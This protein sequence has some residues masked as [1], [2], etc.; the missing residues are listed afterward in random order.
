MVV[1]R[2][3]HAIGMMGVDGFVG[4]VGLQHFDVGDTVALGVEGEA[5]SGHLWEVAVEHGSHRRTAR[6]HGLYLLTTDGNASQGVVVGQHADDVAIGDVASADVVTDAT[7]VLHTDVSLHGMAV[8]IGHDVAGIGLHATNLHL[9][10]LVGHLEGIVAMSYLLRRDGFHQLADAVGDGAD[11]GVFVGDFLGF[12]KVCRHTTVRS[13]EQFTDVGKL[14]TGLCDN[15]VATVEILDGHTLEN[16]VGMAI[17]HDIDAT[18]IV[19]EQVGIEAQR[20]GGLTDVGEQYHVVGTLAT[21][22]IDGLLDE[23]VEGLRLEVVEQDAVGVVEGIALEDHRFGRAGSDEGNLLVAILMDD[24]RCIVRFGGAGIEEIDARHG[25]TNLFQQL[26]HAGHAIIELMVAQR[27]GVVVHQVHDVGN[28]L[29]LRDGSGGVALQEV[30]HADS[31]GIGRIRTVDGV[32]QSGHCLVAVDAAM[33]V[34]LVE[35]HDALLSN[36]VLAAQQ[37]DH[38]KE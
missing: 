9:V 6:E 4:A 5:Q 33:D 24:I 10:V 14:G 25:S 15:N 31:T 12:E 21:G 27:Q 2:D 35:Y 32:T 1:V 19:D 30:A 3:S 17:E 16:F 37:E 28:I 18:R 11:T 34:I 23:L 38:G 29:S 13:D 22:F 26:T 8:G 7:S 36:I 20:L